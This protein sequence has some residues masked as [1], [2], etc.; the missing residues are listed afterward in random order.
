MK[1]TNPFID[2]TRYYNENHSTIRHSND[3]WRYATKYKQLKV[4]IARALI[5][6]HWLDIFKCGH[7]N[8]YGS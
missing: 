4:R 1:R 2:A 3:V 5:L 8:R 7:D 6:S